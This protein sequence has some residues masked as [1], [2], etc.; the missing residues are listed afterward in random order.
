MNPFFKTAICLLLC[1]SLCFS[2]GC[3]SK[4]EAPPDREATINTGTVIT[5]PEIAT[6]KSVSAVSVSEAQLTEEEKAFVWSYN[7]LNETEQRLYRI[8]LNMVRNL[9]VGWIDMGYL[10]KD[11]SVNVARAYRAVSNDFPEYYWMPVSYYLNVHDSKT[12]VAFKKNDIEDGYGFTKEQIE[13]NAEEFYDSIN[14]IVQKT[15]SAESDFEKELIIHDTLCKAVT[16]DS[17]FDFDGKDSIYTAYG[18]LVNGRAVCEGY[19]RA[20]KLLCRYAGIKCILV[21]GDSRGVGHMWNMV[22]L[23]SRWYHVD[24]T[25]NDLR[26]EPLHTYLNL[27][28]LSIRADHDIDISYSKADIALISQGNSF[29]FYLPKAESTELNY[30]IQKGLV[31]KDDPISPLAK[32]LV[33]AYNNG[34]HK[35]E[36]L[37]DS[38]ELQKDFK[39][40]YES[41]VVEIQEKCVEQM[42]DVYFKLSSLSFPSKTC[43]IY[44]EEYEK[45]EFSLWSYLLN[46]FK[47]LKSNKKGTV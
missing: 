39:D 2:C 38:Q 46:K 17:D 25:W 32:E 28:E 3:A 26:K 6:D 20:F 5:A 7:F 14:R 21:T 40:N 22:E 42:G 31:I 44:F 24:I 34:L 1:L 10:G 8:M 45:E 16:Y 47:N 35:A 19:A 9:T 41:Y 37:F 13:D 23:D 15:E 43:V 27:T 36:F 11:A 33:T 18:A 30:Y 12:S 4:E 29:N